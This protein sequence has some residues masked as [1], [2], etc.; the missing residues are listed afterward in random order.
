M[1]KLTQIDAYNGFRENDP[2]QMELFIITLKNTSQLVF[3]C[4]DAA[5]AVEQFRCRVYSMAAVGRY[6]SRRNSLV[7]AFVLQEPRK[8]P[9]TKRR[10]GSGAGGLSRQGS[11]VDIT[12]HDSVNG[13][14][15]SSETGDA[16]GGA[17]SDAPG[18]TSQTL[19]AVAAVFGPV[20]RG[21]GETTEAQDSSPEKPKAQ[22][23]LQRSVSNLDRAIDR[24]QTNRD[25]TRW[26]SERPHVAFILLIV[27]FL[28]GYVVYVY[29]FEEGEAA[30]Q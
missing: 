8:T 21:G 16:P 30:C 27:F 25:A 17:P 22:D 4:D 14:E 29:L 28:V 13:S 5:Y 6:Q 19:D 9:A 3:E 20:A 1:L 11:S 26:S 12:V 23:T 7:C 2:D 15:T 10:D 18:D 24:D